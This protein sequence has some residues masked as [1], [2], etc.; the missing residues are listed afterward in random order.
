MKLLGLSILLQASASLSDAGIFNTDSFSSAIKNQLENIGL[1]PDDSDRTLDVGSK[2]SGIVSGGFDKLGYIPI[3]TAVGQ[4]EGQARFRVE[5]AL[6][7][8][9]R[10][11]S[12]RYSGLGEDIE[13][14]CRGYVE[15]A[16]S[17]CMARVESLA[18]ELQE[19]GRRILS[20]R[21]EECQA[22]TTRTTET[23]ARQEEERLRRE[24]EREQEELTRQYEAR[25]RDLE[26]EVVQE[27]EERGRDVETR[28]R[29]EYESRGK[30]EEQRIRQELELRGEV[31]RKEIELELRKRGEVEAV[32]IREEFEERGRML[33]GTLR[34]EFEERGEKIKTE[35]EQE[36]RDKGNRLRDEGEDQCTEMINMACEDVIEGSESDDFCQEFFFFTSDLSDEEK[37]RLRRLRKYR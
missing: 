25:G 4:C 28:I 13:A 9:Q 26:K 19:L 6:T 32:Q 10:E 33:E 15:F 29:R 23:V 12:Q 35:V 18:G 34:K 1:V 17:Q 2:I 8:L 31:K 14:R 24:G 37:R 21:T 22:E 3:A 20:E 16:G 27:F 5:N 7:Q 36:F 11:L 30:G